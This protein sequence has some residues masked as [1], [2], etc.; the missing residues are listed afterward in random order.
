DYKLYYSKLTEIVKSYFEE[1]VKVDALEST[2]NELIVKLELLKDA[3]QLDISKETLKNFKSVLSTADLVKF[4]KSAPGSKTAILDKQLLETVLVDTKEAMPKPT[5]EELLKN[6]EYRK[7]T[8]KEKKRKLLFKI[9]KILSLMTFV[10]LLA[11]ISVFGWQEVKDNLLGNST[12]EFLQKEDWVESSYGAFPIKISSPDVL[13]RSDSKI[14]QLFSFQSLEDPFSLSISTRPINKD[15]DIQ[16]ILMEKLKSNGA[17]NIL[18]QQEEF[19]LNNG[20]STT[21]YYVSFDYLNM[22]E[23]SVKKEYSSLSFFENGGTQTLNIIVDRD[24]KYAKQIRT[25][26][27]NSIDF[28]KK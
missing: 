18:T 17:L 22:E 15:D 2:T 1:E 12:K 13:K 7:K 10:L 16:S 5:E 9:A 21:R 4:A 19:T 28:N 14:G 6:E 24:N 8:E 3:G 23:V 27:E 20:T 11:S 25:R 26:I